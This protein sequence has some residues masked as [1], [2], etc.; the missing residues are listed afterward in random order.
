MTEKTRVAITGAT[1]GLGRELAV[2]LARRRW[3]VAVTGR[4]RE[5]LLDTARAVAEAGGEP[6]ALEGSVAARADV[7]RHYALIREK[8]G[9]LDWAILNAGVGSSMSAREFSAEEVRRTLETNVLGAAYWL[10]AVL[11]DMIQAGCGL[12]AGISSLA[13]YRGLPGSGAYCASKAALNALLESARV[14][15]IGTGVEVVTVCPGFVKTE[16]TACR[17]DAWFLLETEDGVRRLLRGIDR[18]RR[19]VHFPW[20]L[21]YPMRHVAPN[22]PGW[23]Y[24]LLASRLIR[25]FKTHGAKP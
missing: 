25:R 18:R 7:E 21:S 11:P 9:G 22:L 5:R 23:L 24:D 12:V 19:V 4:R 3:R 6:L 15:L 13:S 16:M 17:Q 1:S 8:W 20:Q 10:E 14:D 2:Q